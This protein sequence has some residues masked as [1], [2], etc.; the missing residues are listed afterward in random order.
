MRLSLRGLY[1]LLKI[2]LNGFVKAVAVYPNL[3]S[4]DIPH[5]QVSYIFFV[6]PGLS[7]VKTPKVTAKSIKPNTEAL[8]GDNSVKL[9]WTD[10]VCNQSYKVIVCIIFVPRRCV[11]T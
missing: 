10:L 9:V 1:K 7:R 6:K 3:G 4:G 11:F 8:F 5:V 2:T